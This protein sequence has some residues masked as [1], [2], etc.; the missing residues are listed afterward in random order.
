MNTEQK[1]FRALVTGV[2]LILFL[3]PAAFGQGSIDTDGD[4]VLDSVECP[5][6]IF[7]DTDGDG[8]SDCKDIDDD[9]DGV[10]TIEE[11]TNRDTD[12]DG[13]VDHL[14]EDD[15]GDGESTLDEI[16]PYQSD[17]DGDY[18]LEHL[19]ADE[20]DGPAGDLD[21][22]GLTNS[23]EECLGSDPEDSDT[24]GDGVHDED[25]VDLPCTTARDTDGDGLPDVNDPDDDGDG[26]PTSV[27]HDTGPYGPKDADDIWNDVDSDGVPNYL[28]LDSDGDGKTDKSEFFGGRLPDIAGVPLKVTVD[29]RV[30]PTTH[31]IGQ[32]FQV[33]D[34]DADGIPNWLDSQDEDGPEGDADGDGL[35]NWREENRGSNPYNPDS[36]GDGIEDGDEHG[37]ADGDGVINRLDPD[38]DGDG[39]PTGEEG[40]SDVDQDGI[41][42]H[43][44]LDSDG[45]GRPDS[46]DATPLG[47]CVGS[48]FELPD[49][50]NVALGRC[51][52]RDC[53]GIADNQESGEQF[54]IT[55]PAH[56]FSRANDGKW[57]LRW[58]DGGTVRP[59]L[60]DGACGFE[61][62]DCDLIQNCA[63]RD[64]TD[65]PG[66]NGTGHF[67][68]DL[69]N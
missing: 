69:L 13:V 37:D 51:T 36:D 48:A 25:E 50:D 68:C 59:S 66:Q 5:G 67:F 21:G 44:D 32:S 28:D 31:V 60:C 6:G 33:P 15:D 45:D 12:G 41:P 29:I 30:N 9:G 53:D 38:D 65:G 18:I 58:T 55:G 47:P 17:S 1:P 22:D 2:A 24:D 46:A 40:S 64:W 52:D 4:A 19:D 27:E 57:Y 26:I 20:E 42:N 56:W 34:G 23:E 16:S 63:D 3:T 8:I 11:G 14:D 43:L 7:V 10:P 39:I 35:V 49:G 54:Y 62:Y 61:D